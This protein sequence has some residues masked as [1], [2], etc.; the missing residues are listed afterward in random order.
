MVDNLGWC[1]VVS[2]PKN[3]DI[4][5]DCQLVSLPFWKGTDW[6]IK[7]ATAKIQQTSSISQDLNVSAQPRAFGVGR[8]SP[9][10]ARL[11]GSR[12]WSGSWEP[13]ITAKLGV[14][15]NLYDKSIRL[16]D[17][18]RGRLLMLG[19][20]LIHCAWSDFSDSENFKYLAAS[21]F[22]TRRSNCSWK[23]N[24]HSKGLHDI[25]AHQDH[26]LILD[27]FRQYAAATAVYSVQ[28]ERKSSWEPYSRPIRV[29]I[30]L[31]AT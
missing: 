15:E 4:R 28:S 1:V 8:T 10:L 2:Q 12:A 5:L 6:P 30:A 20:C 26:V 13:F 29:K 21:M 27:L 11:V 16:D 14:D 31:R 19:E 25:S 3:Y 23:L 24:Q 18:A 9:P 22:L 7:A 17:V